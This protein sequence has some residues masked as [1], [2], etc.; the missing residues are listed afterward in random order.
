M[1]NKSNRSK[2][3][4]LLAVAVLVIG[5]YALPQTL[6]LFAGMH[7]FNNGSEVLCNKCHSDIYDEMTVPVSGVQPPHTSF[8]NP[9]GPSPC[10]SCH[11]TGYIQIYDSGF[12]ISSSNPNLIDDG[13][14]KWLGVNV[15]Q[16]H[17]AVT[18][19]CVFCHDIVSQEI[20]NSSEAHSSYYN[21]SNQSNLLKGG[22][23]ACIGC[24]THTYINIIWRRVKGYDVIA[25]KTDDGY[26]F[27]FN[28]N[29][30]SDNIQTNYSAG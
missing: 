8:S 3:V 7:T 21:A 10:T 14:E 17:S 18:V 30:S 1:E 23:E 4:G 22:N 15:S 28:V 24:H 13:G 19:E 2:R 26:S 20:I 25:N 27:S 16:A 9:T 5:L 12:G 6:S 29:N 11:R